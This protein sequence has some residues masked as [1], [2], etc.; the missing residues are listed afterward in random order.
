MSFLTVKELKVFK[1]CTG[2][3]HIFAEFKGQDGFSYKYRGLLWFCM[4]QLPRFGG[5]SGQWVYDRVMA[6]RCPNVIPVSMQNAKLLDQMYEERAG[7]VY[8]AVMALKDVIDNG[9]RFSEPEVVRINRIEYRHDNDSALE[10]MDQ[11]MVRRITPPKRNDRVTVTAIYQT[12]RVWY[13]R[14]YGNPFFKAK[15]DFYAA[16]ASAVGMAYGDMKMKTAR[17][18]VLRDFTLNPAYFTENDDI[19]PY[20]VTKQDIVV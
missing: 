9:Y 18:E 2:G 8:K 5:D 3:D 13:Q 10:F 14:E 11:C 16:I 20:Q 17:G 7:I 15:K 12:Y 1:C 19:L 6:V 4:N